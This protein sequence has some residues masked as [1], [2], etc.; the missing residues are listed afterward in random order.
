[1]KPK[2]HHLLIKHEITKEWLN[3]ENLKNYLTRTWNQKQ[4]FNNPQPQPTIFFHAVIHPKRF[5]SSR[6]YIKYYFT[7]WKQWKNRRKKFN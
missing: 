5:I 4:Y 2:F 3:L 1:M 6:P 7:N